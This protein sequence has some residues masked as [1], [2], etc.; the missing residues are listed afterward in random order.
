MLSTVGKNLNYSAIDFTDTLIYLHVY[1][2]YMYMYSPAT[3]LMQPDVLINLTTC[4][5][6]DKNSSKGTYSQLPE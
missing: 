6:C 1:L 3:Y 4:L 5:H 2:K